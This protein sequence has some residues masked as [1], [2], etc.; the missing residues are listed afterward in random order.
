M[1]EANDHERKH[2][3]HSPLLL[4]P[5]PPT[6]SVLQSHKRAYS[7]PPSKFVLHGDFIRKEKQKV[8]GDG[9]TTELKKTTLQKEEKETKSKKKKKKNQKCVDVTC[10]KTGCIVWVR[11]FAVFLCSCFLC[12]TVVPKPRV[13]WTPTQVQWMHGLTNGSCYYCRVMFDTK[14]PPTVRKGV[15]EMDHFFPLCLDG[16]D[17]IDN[18]VPSCIPCNS[19]KH[20]HSPFEYAASHHVSLRC[21]YISN[22]RMCLRYVTRYFANKAPL[23]L[24]HS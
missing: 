21:Q 24:D 11:S 7:T 8:D 17:T 19:A 13:R 9:G 4:H 15:W 5:L 16:L 14:T 2:A 22:D 20:G 12:C 18:I 23:F 1:W 10:G 6:R 3:L